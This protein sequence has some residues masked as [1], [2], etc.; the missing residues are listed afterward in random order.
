MLTAF[1]AGMPLLRPSIALNIRAR[2]VYWCRRH[3]A[4]PAAVLNTNGDTVIV[5][6]SGGR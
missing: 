3:P 5:T 1:A 2:G 6:P 4:P